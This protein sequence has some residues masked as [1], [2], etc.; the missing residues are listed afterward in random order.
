MSTTIVRDDTALRDEAFRLFGQII[1]RSDP[2]RL[3][4]WANL[5]LTITQLRVLFI[6]RGEP[7]LAAGA[8]AERLEVTPSTLTRIIDRLNRNQMIERV[9]DVE[10]RR[11]VNHYLS[12]RGAELVAEVERGFRGHMDEV[13]NRLDRG[14]LS[15]L[16]LA[17]RD[18][19]SA[20]DAVAADPAA[21]RR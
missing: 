8:L 12:S 18:F 10:D 5:G 14:S 1:A 17:L 6:L 11:C 2:S 4:Q 13:L 16:V 3:D 15:R 20:M 19:T 21:V 7:G 9:P